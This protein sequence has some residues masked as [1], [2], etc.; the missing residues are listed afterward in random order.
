M[1]I[2]RRAKARRPDTAAGDRWLT[3]TINCAPHDVQT[4]KLPA[5]LQAYGEPHPDTYPA[6]AW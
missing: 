6:G 4:H 5:P 2:R 1:I 3:V